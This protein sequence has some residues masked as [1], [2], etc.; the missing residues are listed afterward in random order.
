MGRAGR[1][2]ETREDS[3]NRESNQ[4]SAAALTHEC[5][6]ENKKLRRNVLDGAGF[7]RDVTNIYPVGRMLRQIVL[8]KNSFL[9]TN[10]RGR[11]H[12]ELRQLASKE[13][14]FREF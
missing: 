4:P 2:N 5:A 9:R 11:G 10:T 3:R 13:R 1:V 8:G 7:V 14:V 6:Q 12:I